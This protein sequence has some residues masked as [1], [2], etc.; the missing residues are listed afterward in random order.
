MYQKMKQL[1]QKLNLKHDDTFCLA[2]SFIFSQSS[3]ATLPTEG[4]CQAHSTLCSL[5]EQYYRLLT[6]ILH[7]GSMDSSQSK[8]LHVGYFLSRFPGCLHAHLFPSGQCSES[9][10]NQNIFLTQLLF[11]ITP[12][13]YSGFK[14]VHLNISSILQAPLSSS[15]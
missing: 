3:A 15:K 13:S 9:S 2:F 5:D 11:L 8:K 14:I 4:G 10:K 1:F 6:R 7:L 12:A